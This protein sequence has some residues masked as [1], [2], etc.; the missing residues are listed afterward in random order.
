MLLGTGLLAEGVP[1]L[2]QNAAAGKS[3][4]AADPP[5]PAIEPARLLTFMKMNASSADA[6]VPWYYTG[7]IYAAQ[8][9]KAPLHLFDFEGSEIYSVRRTG[10]TDWAVLGSTLTFFRDRST[11]AYLDRFD[12][13]LTGVSTPVKPNR[14]SSPPDKPTRI[15]AR[16]MA[17]VEAETI[18][19]NINLQSN[20]GVTW[21]TTSRYLTKMPQPWIEVQS[22]FAP[23]SQVDDASLASTSS[24]FVSTYLA[25]WLGWMNM[26]EVPG[27]MVWHAAGRKL[28]NLDE[29]PAAYRKRADVTA[30]EHFQKR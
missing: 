27:H 10:A 25:P 14:L 22:M 28:A 2:A 29:L 6:Q 23:T 24:T 19:W 12:N 18:P 15:S 21:L 1:A 3:Q 26:K 11:G 13:P 16:G 8:E 20:G 9:A 17:I 5:A 7:R 30:A 4:V